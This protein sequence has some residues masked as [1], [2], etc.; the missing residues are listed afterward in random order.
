MFGRLGAPEI[1]LILVVIIL[2]FGAKK[3]PDMARSL[4]KSAR[5]LK[6]EAKAMKDEG[7]TTAPADPPNNTDEQPPAQRI[8]QAAPG[9]ATNARPVNEPTD[10]TKR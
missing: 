7:K 2:L 1:I 9:D 5:I 10:T 8:I 3:L 4:G 6:S